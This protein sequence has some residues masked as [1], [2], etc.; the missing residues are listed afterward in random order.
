MLTYHVRPYGL[1]M[2]VL[3]WTEVHILSSD[4]ITELTELCAVL[5]VGPQWWWMAIVG[6]HWGPFD[7]LVL[8]MWVPLPP[9]PPS[10]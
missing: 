7:L 3:V 1:G 10:W 8:L 9:P 4:C 2:C 6:T 5:E